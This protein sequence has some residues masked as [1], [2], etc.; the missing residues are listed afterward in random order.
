MPTWLERA[1]PSELG[2]Y[3]GKTASPRKSGL[4]IRHLCRC[5]PELFADVLGLALDVADRY[6]APEIGEAEL[7]AALE[8]VTEAR[9]RTHFHWHTEGSPTARTAALSAHIA[10]EVAARGF[11]PDVLRDLRNAVLGN[12]GPRK[13][14]IAPVM[15][16]LF[17]EHFGDVR[18]PVVSDPSWL[19]ETVVL[20]AQ[21]MYNAR[22]FG[23]MPILADALQDAGCDSDDILNHCRGPG[24]HVRG[25]WVVDLLLGKA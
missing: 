14:P 12:A 2:V 19:T 15:R 9:D 6:E 20:L 10:R 11:Y 18:R 7:Q 3:L 13:N 17:L 16:P 24:P 23:A 21:G 8:S 4:F 5:F 25:C 22:D 1:Q